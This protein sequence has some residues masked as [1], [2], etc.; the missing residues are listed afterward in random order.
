MTVPN[1]FTSFWALIENYHLGDVHDF[2]L[3]DLGSVS[4]AQLF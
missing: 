4:N 3:N 2:V 1:Y